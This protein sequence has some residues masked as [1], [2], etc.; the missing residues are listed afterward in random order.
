MLLR[1]GNKLAKSAKKLTQKSM[2]FIFKKK[3][4]KKT[5]KKPKKHA[6]SIKLK[7]FGGNFY[8]LKK[9]AFNIW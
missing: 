8:F 4:L 2:L 6:L 7:R 3:R 1:Y 5:A 9:H